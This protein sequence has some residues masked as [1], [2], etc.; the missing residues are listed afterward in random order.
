[1][2]LT[3]QNMPNVFICSFKAAE[4][5]A[6]SQEPV[7]A[8]HAAGRDRRL[9]HAQSLAAVQQHLDGPLHVGPQQLF[10]GV[11]DLVL[12]QIKTCSRL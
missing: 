2:S 10:Q 11:I 1:M 4:A 8:P 3:H 12:S 7:A 6:D 9:T 5:N